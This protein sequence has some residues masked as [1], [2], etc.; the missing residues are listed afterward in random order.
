[1][2]TVKV[3]IALE[4]GPDGNWQANGYGGPAIDQDPPDWGDHMSSY[5]AIDD[6]RRYWIEVEV[7]VPE[8]EPETLAGNAVEDTAAPAAEE[9][10]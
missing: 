4:I 3:R 9:A 5:D 8:E 7:P 1:M 2:K 6:G 10:A